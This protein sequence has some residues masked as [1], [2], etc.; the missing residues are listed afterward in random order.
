VTGAEEG[1]PN[2]G[3]TGEAGP[4][5]GQGPPPDWAGPGYA[6][7]PVNQGAAGAG[8]EGASAYDARA[9]AGGESPLSVETEGNAF[10]ERPELFIG[11][12]FVG[13]FALAQILRRF[14]P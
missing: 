8:P 9:E 1:A 13:G 12:A 10:S 11:A 6:G 7:A 3:A 14:G 2:Q 4:A 5:E